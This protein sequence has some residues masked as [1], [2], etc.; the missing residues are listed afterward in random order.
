MD[1]K[2]HKITVIMAERAADCLSKLGLESRDQPTGSNQ[3]NA[4]TPNVLYNNQPPQTHLQVGTPP[5]S[6]SAQPE[7][8]SVQ[9]LTNQQQPKEQNSSELN[10]GGSSPFNSHHRR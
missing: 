6:S 5:S 1:F 10:A 2:F 9:I 4:Q 7:H 8:N 3:M